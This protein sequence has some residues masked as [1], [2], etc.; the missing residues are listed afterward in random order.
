MITAVS[1]KAKNLL[2][3]VI[4]TAATEPSDHGIASWFVKSELKKSLRQQNKEKK[5]I[6]PFKDIPGR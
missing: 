1:I 2:S 5:G 3:L 6:P 4:A